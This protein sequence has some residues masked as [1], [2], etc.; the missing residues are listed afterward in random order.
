[1]LGTSGVGFANES[2]VHGSQK[3]A[4]S[5]RPLFDATGATYPSRAM[6]YL[7]E[8]IHSP[9]VTGLRCSFTRAISSAPPIGEWDSLLLAPLFRP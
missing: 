9:T 1:M 6:A 7:R 2:R 8:K 3:S 5:K 4:Q